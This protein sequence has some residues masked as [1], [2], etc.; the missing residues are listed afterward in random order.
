MDLL[1]ICRDAME[2]SIIANVA[3]ALE[4]K[5]RGKDA[6]VL[7]TEEALD[8]LAGSSLTWARL[9][10]NRPSRIAI[11]R[12]ATEMGIPIASE[13]DDRW[14]DVPRLL[15]HAREAGVRLLACPIWSEIL[16]ID[17]SLPDTIEGVSTDELMTAFESAQVIGSY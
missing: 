10:Q 9:F 3:M 5:R 4:A 11:S 2:N 16:H 1:F 8:G 14:T 17:G 15:S 12:G 7:F 6:A 13:R